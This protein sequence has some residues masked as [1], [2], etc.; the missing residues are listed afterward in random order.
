MKTRAKKC[1]HDTHTPSFLCS[2]QESSRRAPAR[3]REPF[4]PKD[5]GSLIPVTSTGMR[6]HGSPSLDENQRGLLQQCLDGLDEDRR[7]PPIDNPVIEAR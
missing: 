6:E 1:G 7:I 3:W 2:S 4:Q 5:L